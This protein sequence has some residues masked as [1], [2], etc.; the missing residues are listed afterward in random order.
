MSTLELPQL[1]IRY[2]L[3][4]QDLSISSRLKKLLRGNSRPVA[5]SRPDVIVIGFV[6]NVVELYGGLPA[7]RTFGKVF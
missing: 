4:L 2:S 5:R 7:E 1:V 6:F 3:L